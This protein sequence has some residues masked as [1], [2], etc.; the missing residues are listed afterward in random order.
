MKQAPVL[1]DQD[2]KRMLKHWGLGGLEE[3]LLTMTRGPRF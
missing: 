1:S 2:M 3:R